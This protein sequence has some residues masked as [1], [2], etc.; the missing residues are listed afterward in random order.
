[1]VAKWWESWWGFQPKSH[2]TPAR[3]SAWVRSLPLHHKSNF[4]A[5]KRDQVVEVLNVIL[6]HYPQEHSTTTTTMTSNH[7]FLF[8]GSVQSSDLG[9]VLTAIR[10]YSHNVRQATGRMLVNVNIN[11]ATFFRHSS[12]I[13]LINGAK[14]HGKTFWQIERFLKK[15]LV[16][17]IHL[18][19]R[20][21]KAGEK[22]PR[23]VT[24]FGLAN[25]DDGHEL[26]HPPEVHE[27]GANPSQANQ[28]MT[29]PPEGRY[30][31]VADYFEQRYG[32]QLKHPKHSVLKLGTRKNPMYV[33]PE[34][35]VV[36]PGQVSMKRLLPEQTKRM[37]GFACRAPHLN[38]HDIVSQAPSVLG[39]K[40]AADPLLKLFGLSIDPAMITVPGRVLSSPVIKYND[41]GS[42]KPENGSWIMR[43]VQVAS[44]AAFP[45][46]TYLYIKKVGSQTSRIAKEE[47]F[48][49]F[50]GK[51]RAKM[52]DV[53]LAVPVPVRGRVITLDQTDTLNSDQL[54]EATLSGFV[55][56]RVRLAYI[57]LNEADTVLY[58]KIEYLGDVQLGLH[59]VCSV[60]I[61]AFQDVGQPDYLAQ[62]RHKSQLKTGRS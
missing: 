5:S 7:H 20:R 12:V 13:D 47:D 26:P 40:P 16:E 3:P 41:R 37:I 28:T 56:N 45:A 44:A 54:I 53:G 36:V 42:F 22:L 24:I 14:A 35:L 38:A 8:R 46:W 10:G 51:L 39:L 60:Q 59:T 32:R 57:I 34:F 9:G 15:I 17:P 31:T 4:S 43:G 30:M 48:H 1:M 33:P 61:K 2:R 18:P 25:I 55:S 23:V 11:H 52:R 6:S 58:N 27:W 49:E 21:N 62:Y 50:A 29:A 19:V